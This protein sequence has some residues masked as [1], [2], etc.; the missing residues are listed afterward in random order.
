[1]LGNMLCVMY[2]VMYYVL[3]YVFFNL[4][5]ILMMLYNCLVG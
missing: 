3:C 4:Y 1:M 2:Y 5:G